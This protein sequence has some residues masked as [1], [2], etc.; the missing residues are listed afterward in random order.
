VCKSLSLG[1]VMKAQDL[2]MYMCAGS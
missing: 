1:S 2:N